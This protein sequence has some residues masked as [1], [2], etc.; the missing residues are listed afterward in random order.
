VIALDVT[1]ILDGLEV[2]IVGSLGGILQRPDTLALSAIEIGWAGSSYYAWS[3]VLQEILS[4][5]NAT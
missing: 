1:W 5:Y 4:N 2:T 3:Q